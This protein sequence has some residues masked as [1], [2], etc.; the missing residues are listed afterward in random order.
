MRTRN[1]RSATLTAFAVMVLSS[2]AEAA[3]K[4]VA[5]IK[6]VHS[7]V[8][9]VMAG[10]AEPVLL[11]KGAGSPHSYSLRPSE[12]RALE[13]AELVFWVGEALETF[14]EK[15]LEA[16]AS[17][18]KLVELMELDDI[19]LLRSREGGA[20]ES[21]AHEEEHDHAHHE[22]HGES[23]EHAE[24][25]H[26]E[27]HQEAHDGHGHDHAH[28][29]Y[30]AHIW[31]DPHNAEAIVEAAVAAL[32]DIDPANAA[33]YQGNGKTVI[34]EIERL[35]RDLKAMLVPV[36]DAPYIVFHDAYRYFEAHYGT[37]AVGSI[38]VTPDQAPGAKRLA[39]IRHRI[40][41]LGATCVFSEPQFKPAL[42]ETVAEGTKARTGELDP[43]GAE[44]TP[45]RGAYG[46][47]MRGL[48]RSLV[49]CL[50]PTS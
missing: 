25:D 16:L 11:V 46:E 27:E 9:G 2:G 13:A 40:E 26:D 1:W 34:D 30:D 10:V 38:T 18:A 32:S 43:L 7:L 5:S 24:H 21:E 14:L 36:K 31:L 22:E 23:D 37:N 3:P 41:D 35:D 20:W 44:I 19:E 33:H 39:E 50:E 4:V 8:A 17:K 47:L 28:G 49:A 29:L 48:G 6:P 45:G 15:P 42:V 12:A